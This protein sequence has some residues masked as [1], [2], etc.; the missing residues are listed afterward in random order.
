MRESFTPDVYHGHLIGL[1]EEIDIED[2]SYQKAAEEDENIEP[3]KIWIIITCEYQSLYF[4]ECD[5][6]E[7]NIE[8]EAE[9]E[10]SHVE[11]G[12][13]GAPD[14]KLEERE[15]E[16]VEEQHWVEDLDCD[17]QRHRSADCKVCAGYQRLGEIPRF[18]F[19][20]CVLHQYYYKINK[21]SSKLC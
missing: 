12:C 6:G 16:G 5:I 7:V 14:V 11:Q 20:D 21:S 4:G 3:E 13:E 1:G 9:A 19:R 2:A 15:L 10:L 17:Q 8:Y 18:E